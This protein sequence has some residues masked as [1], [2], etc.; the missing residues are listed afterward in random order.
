MLRSPDILQ[1]QL[2]EFASMAY[3]IALE[4]TGLGLTDFYGP[5]RGHKENRTPRLLYRYIFTRTK[6]GY[7]NIER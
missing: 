1:V 5:G 2:A 6:D 4:S 3:S 7:K